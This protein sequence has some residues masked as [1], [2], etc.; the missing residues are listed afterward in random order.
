SAAA[1]TVTVD[2]QLSGVAVV[3]LNRPD[4]CNAL[5]SMMLDSIHKMEKNVRAVV[6]CGA[7]SAFCAGADLKERKGMTNAQWESQHKIFQRAALTFRALPMPTIAA[8][9][10][11]A[12]GGGFEL[13]LLADWTVACES[14]K[15]GFP[16]VNYG[17]FPGLGGTQL[18]SR[19]IGLPRAKRLILTGESI[20]AQEAHRMGIVASVQS[21]P[22][23]TIQAAIRDAELVASKPPGAIER[24][25][26][27]IWEG[28][29]VN[30]F[31]DAWDY[32]LGLYSECVR[33]DERIQGMLAAQDRLLPR[34]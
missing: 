12:F 18:L 24:A 34:Q 32:S 1:P 13:A 26:L 10:G 19:Y 23:A 4:A 7:G 11:H 14:A 31:N 30:T 33:S 27:A 22:E 21:C 5:N 9:N 25:K 16:E 8:L 20:S 15:L 17:I 28:Y 29:Q 6:L 3:Q 2:I